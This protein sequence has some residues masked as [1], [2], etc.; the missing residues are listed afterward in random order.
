[1]QCGK[2]MNK[3]I[4][5][6]RKKKN[7]LILIVLLISG[8]LI[9]FYSLAHVYEFIS[10]DLLNTIYIFVLFGYL[11]FVVKIKN[12]ITYYNYQYNYLLMLNEDL[13]PINTT[14]TLFDNKWRQTL[15]EKGLELHEKTSELEIYYI[16]ASKDNQFKQLNR[17]MISI[18]IN[19]SDKLDLYDDKIQQSIKRIYEKNEK[20]TK[21]KNEIIIHFKTYETLDDKSKEEIQKIIAFKQDLFSITNITVGFI[22][23]I[24]KVYYLR[25]EKRFPNKQYYLTCELIK[26]LI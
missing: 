17:T 9:A 4:K 14:Q 23:D 1:M 18:V 15:S 21:V 16:F 7:S 3:K 10:K 24:N 2:K 11:F 20:Q 22:K 26:E 12:T 13:P 25:P 5:K 6:F 8:A 19:H